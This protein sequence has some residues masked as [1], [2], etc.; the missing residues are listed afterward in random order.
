[1]P[2][3]GSNDEIQ[4]NEEDSSG[5]EEASDSDTETLDVTIYLDNDHDTVDDFFAKTNEGSE[6]RSKDDQDASSEA[7]AEKYK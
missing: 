1:M 2:N 6:R 5:E 3:T 4:P 7:D